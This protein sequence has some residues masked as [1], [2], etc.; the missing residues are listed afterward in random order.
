M[1]DERRGLWL[2]HVRAMTKL[3]F[4][5]VH[6][7]LDELLGDA[8]YLGA[9]PGLIAALHTWSQTLVLHP[10]LPCLVTGGGLTVEGQWRVVRNGFLLPVRVVMAVFRGKRLAALRRGL[11]QGQLRR[12]EGRSHQQMANLRNKLGRPKWHVHIRERYPHGTGVLTYLARYLRGGPLANQRLIA[13]ENGTVTFRYRVTGE[14]SDRQQRGRMTLPMEECIRRYLLHVPA[15][16]TP[17]VRWYGLYAPTKR[18]AL[19]GCRAPLGQGPVAQ[20]S[21][22]DWQAACQDRGDDHPERCPVCGRQLVC[23]GVILFEDSTAESYSLGGGGVTRGSGVCSR[24]RREEY[25]LTAR[26]TLP[27][28]K[29]AGHHAMECIG[30]S[31]PHRLCC[32]TGHPR[33]VR[34]GL[35][36]RYKFHRQ[37]VPNS[38]RG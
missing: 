5:A 20:P 12:P 26:N 30:C 15:P 37:G 32:A 6:E 17:V 33:R 29:P 14:A 27:W 36:D 10:H 9:C 34:S 11:A 38:V 28:K 18:E 7:T 1:P 25:A 8:T 13:C 16:G 24:G 2:A 22:L 19:G 31:A 23:L 35:I 4:A 3:L 21:V